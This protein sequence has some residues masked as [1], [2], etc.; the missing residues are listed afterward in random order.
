[1]E[2][3]MSSEPLTCIEQT[4][5]RHI[6]LVLTTVRNNFF[7]VFIFTYFV[8]LMGN[9]VSDSVSVGVKREVTIFPSDPL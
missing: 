6:S 1:M 7:S 8:D 5:T 4:A 9:L 2:A 3:A